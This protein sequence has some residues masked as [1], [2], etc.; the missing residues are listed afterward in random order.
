MTT[1]LDLL[2]LWPERCYTTCFSLMEAS[3]LWTWNT[4]LKTYPMHGT[5][6]QPVETLFTQIQ[7]CVDYAEAGGINI[8]PAQ[9]ISV[10]YA[11]IFATV[12]LMRACH[13]WNG[14][15]AADKTWTTFK[16]HFALPH[17]QHKQM[18][19]KSAAKAGYHAANAAVGQTEDH[20]ADAT[21]GAV[22]NLAT[23]RAAEHGV[24]AL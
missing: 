6:H 11:K 9:H 12:S 1:W 15:E 14:K 8:G 22:A 16:I 17:H 23:S 2:T 20:M 19:G 4:T 24:L 7:D 5:P 10:A 3:Q 18:Q 21:I 13:R